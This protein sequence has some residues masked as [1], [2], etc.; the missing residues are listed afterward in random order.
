MPGLPAR[1]LIRRRLGAHGDEKHG[2]HGRSRAP[3]GHAGT[4]V[5]PVVIR[6]RWPVTGAWR[7]L[8]QIIFSFYENQLY[9]MM[10]DYDR[11][12]TKGMTD[13]DMVDAISASVRTAI[14]SENLE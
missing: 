5:E 6:N 9:R 4:P 10:V 14:L 11:S 8:Q 13:R 1:G 7:G 2:R 12:E 3:C